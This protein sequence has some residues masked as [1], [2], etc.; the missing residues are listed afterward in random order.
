M[1]VAASFL[2]GGAARSGGPHATRSFLARGW[3]AGALD[4]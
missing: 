1:P 3:A 4:L 2:I